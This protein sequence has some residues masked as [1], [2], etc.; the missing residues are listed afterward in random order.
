MTDNN[1]QL[2]VQEAFDYICQNLTI[3]LADENCT[4]LIKCKD[5]VQQALSSGLEDQPTQKQP[6]SLK[7]SKS[8]KSKTRSSA[9]PQGNELSTYTIYTDGA[10]NHNPGG[11]GGCGY[12]II[13]DDTIISFDSG[14]EE[15]TT[16]NRM[17]LKAICQAISHTPKG[18][19]IELYSDSQYAIN[20]A[21][22]GWKRNANVDILA[23]IDKVSSGHKITTHWV[24]G[25]NGNYYN[26]V[27]DNLA[28]EAMYA[29]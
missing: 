13:L 25:H 29:K 15:N 14:R 4:K 8:A 1:Q 28:T 21:F 2:S 6:G 17:E 24:K 3:S 5:I 19:D 22:N 26:E 7:N 20:T 18:V 23:E 9:K 27:C 16:N 10:C 12:V 11:T